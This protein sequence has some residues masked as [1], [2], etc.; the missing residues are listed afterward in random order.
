MRKLVSSLMVAMVLLAAIQSCEHSALDNASSTICFERDIQPIFNSK[1][2]MSG[3]HDAVS[4]EE[5][6]VLTNYETIT[7]RGIVKRNASRSEVYEVIADGEM[8]PRKYPKLTTEEM[9]LIK[10]W[11][12][13]GAK[14]GTNCPSTGCDTTVYSFSGQIQPML[15]KY[16]VGC[17]NAS[18]ASMNVNLSNYTGVKASISQG[19]LRSIDHSGYYPMPKGGTKL[20]PCEITQVSKWIQT[21]APNN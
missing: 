4:R 6:Y 10:D 21:G 18:N 2:A 3:C 5:G 13:S 9:N 19:L 11:I 14:N 15:N 8:P 17:H 12:N 1:C 20:I 16:C 7:S